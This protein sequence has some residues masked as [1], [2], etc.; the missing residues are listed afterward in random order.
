M[1]LNN[2]TV[3]IGSLQVSSCLV[4]IITESPQPAVS[5]RSRYVFFPGCN[6]YLQPEQI[7]NALDIM[8]AI[9]DKYAFLPSLNYCCGGNHLFFGDIKEGGSRTEELVAAIAGFHPE[10][11]MLWCPTCQCRFDKYISPSMDILFETL[12]FPQYLAANMNKLPLNRINA[13]TVT[14]HEACKSVY[15]G[16]DSDGPRE[17]LRQLPRVTFREM[18]HHGQGTVCCGSG[19]IC[20]FPESCAQIRKERL[21]DAA[22]TGAER[23]VTVCHY[24]NQSFATEESH[25]D[26]TVTSYVTLVAET[27][28][29]RREDKF[30][31]YRLWGNLE[32]IL[33]DANNH[34][35]E[36]PFEIE[37]IIEVIQETFLG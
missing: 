33:K 18:N 36:S 17:I 22:Q 15:T 20:W 24:C 25:Y 9:G 37:R 13:G 6:V 26:F 28:G 21:Q 23:L 31:K 8:D 1:T 7:L 34:I 3:H 29:I 30:K 16:V 14:L 35:K 27:M 11:V 32:R 2:P 12:S 19:A 10:A 5:K 4:L